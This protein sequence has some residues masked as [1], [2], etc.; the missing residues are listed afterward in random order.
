MAA[1]AF[2][3][4][5]HRDEKGLELLHKHLA[6]LR[7][8]GLIDVWFDRQIDAGG[9]IDNEIAGALSRS[10]LFLALVSPDVAP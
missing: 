7:R 4:Y 9:K 10:E 5:S 3:S 6:M 8:D 1:N 2:I